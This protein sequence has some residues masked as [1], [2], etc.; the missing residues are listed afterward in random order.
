M[1][2]VRALLAAMILASLA[3]GTVFLAS[4]AAIAEQHLGTPYPDLWQEE[5]AASRCPIPPGWVPY[6]VKQAETLAGLASLVGVNEV[7]L[8]RNN[9]IEGELNPGETLFLPGGGLAPTPSACGPPPGWELVKLEAEERLADIARRYAIEE[10]ALRRANCLG[11]TMQVDAGLRIFV[12][13]TPTVFATQGEPQA[14][15][16]AQA[17]DTAQP[18]GTIEE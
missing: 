3:A 14:T 9:C 10:E 18:A 16:T 8:R 12:P 13:A 4:G 2:S 6:R 15:A 1:Q 17:E 5:G 11:S 7:E